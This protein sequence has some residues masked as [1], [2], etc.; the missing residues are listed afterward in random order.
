MV[1][2]LPLILLASAVESDGHITM[3]SENAQVTVA[4]GGGG[5][6]EFRLLDHSVNPLNWDSAPP[7]SPSP[8]ANRPRGH[9]LCLDRWGR[10]S[11]SEAAKG[12]PFHGEA[13]HSEWTVT[14][15]P[16]HVSGQIVMKMKCRLPIAGFTV[17]RSLAL[18]DDAAVLTV[19]EDLSNDNRLGRIYNMVQHPSLA[20]PFLNE[21]TLVDTNAKRGFCQD[22]P[23]PRS[24]QESASWPQIP[25]GSRA[26][27]NLRRFRA[28]EPD[29]NDVSSFVFEAGA[30]HG[31]VT[32]CSPSH[33]LLIGYVWELDEFPWLN[34]WR[35]KRAGKLAARGVEFGTT[36]YHQPF[37]TLVKQREILGRPLFDFLDAGGTVR[38]SYRM[39]LCR[40]P[41]DFLGV[42]ELDV[43]QLRLAERSPKARLLSVT[44]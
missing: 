39:F 6:V 16:Q 33:E 31:W 21:E 40:I 19:T 14:Q 43:Q 2:L 9:F 25:I 35:S 18:A 37:G 23:L 10:P 42:A 28:S 34:I 24:N 5:I 15:G 3:K 7:S 44:Q 11:E 22:G 27:V 20:P 30:K 36:G 8:P 29:G 26:S 17:T 13:P 32:A 4:V 1:T 41:S 12:M 38:R